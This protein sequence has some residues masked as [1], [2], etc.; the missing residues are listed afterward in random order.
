MITLRFLGSVDL[1]GHNGEL[2]KAA[3]AQPKRLAVLAYLA[4]AIP[5]GFHSRDTLLALLWPELNQMHGRAALRQALYV[6]RRT[7]GGEALVVCGDEV[8]GLNLGR[9]WC[10][11]M[12]FDQAI[13]A[14]DWAAALE[15]YRG[16]LL[17]G[18]HLCAAREFEWWL[19]RAR[20]RLA[21]R[22]ATGAWTLTDQEERNGNLAGALKWAQWTLN[23]SPDDERALRNTIGL[24]H[25]LGDRAGAMR[26]YDHFTRRIAAAYDME[27]TAE[28]KAL[29]SRVRA[30]AAPPIG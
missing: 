5:T 9:V 14:G 23:A 20:A 29:I 2:L 1:R 4:A 7:L 25:R 15:L 13:D 11:V 19:Q 16:E 21:S 27:P 24:L 10:D 8:V 6:L 22:A 26:V 17:A 30:A 3:L 28:T 18:F 12:A